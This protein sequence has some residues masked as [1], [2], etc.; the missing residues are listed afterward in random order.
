MIVIKKVRAP[1]RIDFGG[2]TTDIYPFTRFGGAVLNAAINRYVIG[3]LVKTDKGISLNYHADV[4]TSGGLGS[5]GVMN[6]VWMTLISHIKDKKDLVKRVY[7]LEKILEPAPGKQDPYTSAFGGINFIKIKNDKVTGE[8][9]NLSKKTLDRLEKNLLLVYSGKPHPFLSNK[10]MIDNLVKGKTKDNLIRI[11]D[12]AIDMKNSLLKNNLEEFSGLMNQET[13]QRSKL[14]KSIVSFRMDLII[15][16]AKN[17][18]AVSAKIC[19][20]GGGG[21]ILFFGDKKRLSKAFKK[22][23]IDFQFDFEGLKWL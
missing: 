13:E 21:C 20:A 5:S 9:L 16:K 11:R 3:R 12:I 6:L 18:G 4:P 14:H 10:N 23:K 17:N 15:K 22:E 19:G 7:E 2:G 1:V 8:R